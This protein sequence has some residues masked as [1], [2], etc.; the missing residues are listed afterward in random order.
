MKTFPLGLSLGLAIWVVGCVEFEGQ[1][2]TYR[3]DRK[4]DRLLVFQE[5]Q[6]I[7]AAGNLEFFKK[8]TTPQ[9]I[10]ETPSPREIQELESVMHGQRTFFF[11][12]CF[13]EYDR[14]GVSA[15]LADV[16]KELAT[17]TPDDAEYLRRQAAFMRFV[18]DSVSVANG[19]FFLDGQ[20]RLC[21]YQCVAVNNFSALVSQANDLISA[22]VARELPG[23]TN[24]FSEASREKI[25]AFAGKRRWIQVQGNEI[26]LKFPATLKSYEEYGK[27]PWFPAEVATTY[28]EPFC[29]VLIGRKKQK[30][31]TI[32]KETENAAQSNLVAHVRATYGIAENLD[33]EK[34]RN[35]FLATGE[36]GPAGSPR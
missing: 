24:D 20:G 11:A 36:C 1:S 8:S 25:R 4:N 30:S 34:I 13:L 27:E 3:H 6:N 33:L 12:N 5:Y 32:A 19:T 21:G 17:A 14:E 16:E 29:E 10:P 31:Q 22:T 9:P 15:G 7:H 23:M 26:R 35:V 18:L 2:L 28:S